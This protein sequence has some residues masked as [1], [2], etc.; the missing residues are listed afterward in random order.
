[1]TRAELQ[2]F[3]RSRYDR[4][5]WL[6]LLH[7]L[8]PTARPWMDAQPRELSDPAVVSAA[9]IAHIALADQRNV[10]VLEVKVT[11]QID[12]QRNRSSLRNLVA[13]FIDNQRADAVLAFF[14]GDSGDYR[15]S[16]V[17]RTSTFEVTAEN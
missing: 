9:Q 4:A 8:L 5:R 2:S 10:A 6:V 14:I 12:I 17:A 11:G 3:L 15:F 7:D 1:M 16:F 13:R